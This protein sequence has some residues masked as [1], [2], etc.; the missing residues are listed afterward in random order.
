MSNRES[1]S[2]QFRP[3]RRTAVSLA[4]ETLV[5]AR[6][7]LAESPAPLL[8]APAV[9][10]VNALSWVEAN[11]EQVREQTVRHK[12]VLLRGFTVGD[13]AEFEQVVR[14]VGGDMLEYSYGSTPRSHVAGNVYTSTEYPA[15]Q[16]IPQHN[17][18]AYSRSWPL[19]LGFY[20]VRAAPEG[21]Q[22]PLADSTRVLARIPAAIRDRFAEH[23]VMYVRNYGQGLDLP[24]QD[25]FQ[26]PERTEVEAF[27]D[28]AGIEYEWLADDSLRTRQ[29]CQAVVTHP[30][31]GET[32]WFNQAHLFHISAQ[33][34]EIRETLLAAFGEQGLPRNTYYGDGSPIDEA[35]LDEIRR[36]Y[37]EET[38]MFRWQDGDIAILENMLVSHGRMPYAGPRELVVAMAGAGGQGQ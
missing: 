5:S 13:V 11:R 6:P 12:A 27:C 30:E 21:G 32:A 24:W 16:E 18:M 37:R 14:L 17:E 34:P 36:A 38:V 26:T 9:D 3:R 29:V 35:D 22:T 10:G 8:F 31:T 15:T 33:A 20:S 2:A 25:V 19:K 7:L 1:G 28:R 23:G 4:P